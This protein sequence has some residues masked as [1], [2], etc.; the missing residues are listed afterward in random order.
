LLGNLR[1]NFVS[2]RH[3]RD[4]R[5]RCDLFRAKHYSGGFLVFAGSTHGARGTGPVVGTTTIPGGT[6]TVTVVLA[7][8]DV[9]FWTYDD[10]LRV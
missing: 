9:L 6:V 5:K 10:A 8:R 4:G 7:E 1:I 3:D 2:G